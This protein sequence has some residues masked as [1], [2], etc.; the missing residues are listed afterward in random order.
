MIVGAGSLIWD[1]RQI[2]IMPIPGFKLLDEIIAGLPTNSA[3]RLELAKL[4]ADLEAKDR[5]IAELE[6][7]LAQFAPKPEIDPDAAR[8]LR[9]FV[10]QDDRLT[11][12]QVGQHLSLKKSIAQ[13]HF[14]EL[15]KR[16]FIQC[17]STWGGYDVRPAGR[18]YAVK[19]GLV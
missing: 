2:K 19:H 7:Q 18:E 8:I 15:S 16:G 13:Y 3:Q 17:T 9:V 11:A 14:D 1:V 6:A 4:R 10:E 5:R 12:D